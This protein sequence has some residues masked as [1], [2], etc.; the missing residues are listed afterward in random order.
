MSEVVKWYSFKITLNSCANYLTL[1]WKCSTLYFDWMRYFETLYLAIVVFIA[2]QCLIKCNWVRAYGSNHIQ[3]EHIKWYVTT[4]YVLA[5]L[6]FRVIHNTSIHA[7]NIVQIT[8]E[9]SLIN[10]LCE[11]TLILVTIKQKYLIIA[12]KI[13]FDDVTPMKKSSFWEKNFNFVDKLIYVM[14][15]VYR[16]CSVYVRYKI[17]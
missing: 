13:R 17:N 4:M 11:L 6:S 16:T 5:V 10:N 7:R 1:N 2:E 14:S 8:N 9:T 3:L 12:Q 15:W